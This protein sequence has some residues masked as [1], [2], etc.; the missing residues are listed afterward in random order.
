M[1]RDLETW[2]TTHFTMVAYTN[3]GFDEIKAGNMCKN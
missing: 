1:V 3:R 2:Y